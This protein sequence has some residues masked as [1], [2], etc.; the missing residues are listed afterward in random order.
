METIFSSET[1]KAALV[2][3]DQL[4][5]ERA[6]AIPRNIQR[7][8]PIVGQHGLLAIAVA[9][10][11]RLTGAD[12]D[13]DADAVQMVVHLSVQHPFGQRLF[14]RVKH[15][16]RAEGGPGIGTVEQLVKQGIR[17]SRGFATWHGQGPF[18][19]LGTQTR[20]S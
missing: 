7:Q 13:A 10:V 8:A 4:R 5:V 15:A 20:N 9:G 2:F 6:L 16:V 14:Q 11:D 1:G 18:V 3:G 17:D 19:L 12:A